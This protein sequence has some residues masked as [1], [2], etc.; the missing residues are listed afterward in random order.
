MDLEGWI[1]HLK[2]TLGSNVP[3]VV[4]KENVNELIQLQDHDRRTLLQMAVNS[5]Y[6][7]K[8]MISQLVE[9]GAIIT[10]DLLFSSSL[11]RY[12]LEMGADVNQI[13]P[14]GLC[15]LDYVIVGANLREGMDLIDYGAKPK[16]P[17]LYY[18]VDDFDPRTKDRA[19]KLHEYSLLSDK[20]G[21]VCRKAL[22][23]LIR[24]CKGSKS[25]RGLKDV[26]LEIA[27]QVWRLRGGEGVGPR[28]HLWIKI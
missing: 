7:N 24:V 16:D 6:T 28:G 27:K 9:L 23:T 4:T 20:H 8:R 26:I 22:L 10:C 13:C 14:S 19:I 25:L 15:V 18:L 5:S 21:Q 11:R 12:F 2:Q 1:K 17:Y 3:D